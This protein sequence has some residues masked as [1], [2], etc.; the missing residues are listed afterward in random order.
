MTFRH[1]PCEGPYLSGISANLNQISII[2]SCLKLPDH[3]VTH[4]V[5]DLAL[6]SSGCPPFPAAQDDVISSL[7]SLNP[8]HIKYLFFYMH[9]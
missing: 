2:L 6:T 5:C 3:F 4:K 7:P 8:V 9:W 1:Q